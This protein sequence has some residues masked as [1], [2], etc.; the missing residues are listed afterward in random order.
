MTLSPLPRGPLPHHPR[1]LVLPRRLNH[2][3]LAMRDQPARD[4]D[5]QG[6]QTRKRGSPELSGGM[7]NTLSAQEAARL[8]GIHERTV[9]RA[10][11]SG[12]LAATKQGGSFHIQGED[13]ERY[14]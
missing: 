6:E 9:R 1:S 12:E 14:R 7:P 2:S 13:L 4:A 5:R 11:R 10:I 8:L 3:S